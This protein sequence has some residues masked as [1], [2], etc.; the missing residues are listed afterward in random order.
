MPLSLE[1]EE[2]ERGRKGRHNQRS[3]STTSIAKTANAAVSCHVRVSIG[4]AKV[5]ARITGPPSTQ[6]LLE[7]HRWRAAPGSAEAV[8]SVN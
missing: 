4:R 6:Q 5:I 2:K 8:K 1:E 3:Q 7:L